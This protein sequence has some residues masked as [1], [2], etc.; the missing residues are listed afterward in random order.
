MDR[1]SK[2]EVIAILLLA[3]FFFILSCQPA[4]K[5]TENS[6]ENST[7][8]DVS[9]GN[10]AP[11]WECADENYKVY[12]S[13]NCTRRDATKCERG[14]VNNTCQAAPICTVGFKCID[15]NRKGYQKEDCSFATKVDCEWGCEAGKCNEKP[16]NATNITASDTTS[17]STGYS[18]IAENADENKTVKPST[19]YLL[20]LGEQREI[21]IGGNSHNISIH[22]LEVDQVII[23]IDGIKSDW[24]AEGG[25]FAYSNLGTTIHIKSILFQAYGKKEIEYYLS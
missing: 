24:I 6:T 21:T 16:A 20:S 9:A 18:A 19:F 2:K 1:R 5:S 15:E 12:I 4:A 11:Q 17:S 7:S 23:K 10:C 14:C 22:N 8:T 3:F 13:E 25:S